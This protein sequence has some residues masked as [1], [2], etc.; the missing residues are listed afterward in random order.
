ML[1]FQT[2]VRAFEA[3]LPK[4]LE[5]YDGQ[6]AVIHDGE[7]QA[8]VFPTCEEALGWGYERFGLEPFY[9]KQ[10]NDKAHTTH[11]TRGFAE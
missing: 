9:V 6:Y 11:F 7:V 1:E 5:R 3:A 10:I 8:E 2:E 4:L